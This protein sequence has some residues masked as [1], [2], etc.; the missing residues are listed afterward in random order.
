M[1]PRRR[2]PRPSRAFRRA[3]RRGFT[4][5]ELMV[6][7]VAGLFVAMAVVA[8][9]KDAT[10]TFHEEARTASAEMSLRTAVGRLRSDLERAAFMSTAN[11]QKDTHIAHLPGA[12][13]VP[14]SGSYQGLYKLAGLHLYYEGSKPA[15]PL[16]AAEGLAPDAID[17]SGNFTTTDAYV[18]RILENGQGSCGGQRLE[19]AI[20]SPAMWRILGQANPDAA[21]EAAFQPV[22]GAQFL[23]RVE[24]DTG[25]FQYVPTCSGKA[26]G[27]NGAGLAA[28]AW[29]DV[30]ANGGVKI[31]SAQETHTNGGAT[32]LGI[33]RLRVNPVQT[34]RWELRALD[35]TQ[36]RDAPYAALVSN[37]LDKYELFRTY[38]DALGTLTNQTEIVAEYA[39][40]LKFAFSADLDLA[41]QQQR[42]LTVY[43]LS[44]P[45]NKD[46]ADD[47]TLSSGT[48]APQRIR[49]VRFRLATR[50]AIADRTDS[51][52]APPAN[53]QQGAYPLRYCVLAKGCTP[54]ITGWARMRTITSEVALPN[55]AGV[56]Y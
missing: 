13:N 42:Q 49:S 23:V 28:T 36:P 41:T 46:I 20:D 54:G 3:R 24:D 30:E 17:I 32:G 7:L 45:R 38:V 34:V 47:V 44:D 16:S 56:F 25:H 19:L 21:L 48:E 18:V 11:I 4:L 39:V 55:Q 22:P 6:S 37:N 12:P 40:D 50:S 52:A 35:T 33:G 9:S 14:T 10:D 53:A 2:L 51:L 1:S 29:V 31:L 43:G 8:L 27:V 26:A 5:I 15:T